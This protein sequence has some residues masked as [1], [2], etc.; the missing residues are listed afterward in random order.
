[1]KRLISVILSA[2][3]LISLLTA[4]PSVSAAVIGESSVA[5]SSGTTGDCT[6]S[7]DSSTGN[8]T[9]TGTGDGR[10][11]YYSDE[12]KLPWYS[13]RSKI[14]TLT[15]GKGVT[16]VTQNAFRKCTELTTVKFI[17][18][19]QSIA[20]GAFEYCTKLSVANLNLPLKTIGTYAFSNTALT[21]VSLPLSV[22]NV[23]SSAY[24]GCKNLKSVKVP[25]GCAASIDNAFSGCDA[26]TTVYLGSSVSDIKEAFNGC[27]ITEMTVSSSNP[28]LTMSGSFLL[29]KDKTKLHYYL[30]G[31]TD[32]YA[33]IPS[34]VTEIAD[35]AFSSHDYI[36]SVNLPS[37]LKK[38]G[39]YAFSSVQISSFSFPDSLESVGYQ[40]FY[41]T[42]WLERQP[43]GMV[44][45]GKVAYLY[46]G[47][48]PQSVSFKSDTLGIAGGAFEDSTTLKSITFPSTLTN[49]G[50]NAFSH[51]TN[52]SSM[53][54]PRSLKSIGERAFS[55]CSSLTSLVMRSNVT[56]LG[57][58]C[59][60]NCTSLKS[61]EL[62][63]NLTK[64]PADC[65]W[66]CIALEG[67]IVIPKK[68]EYIGE[69]AFMDT[70]K[71]NSF[72]VLNPDMQY[73]QVFQNSFGYGNKT[74]TMY[75]FKDSTAQKYASDKSW[76]F[77]CITEVKGDANFDGVVTIRD[78]TAIQR[79]VSEY[80]KLSPQAITN[81][82]M[83]HNS[84]A[85]IDDA[86]VIQ[87]YLAEY[88][89]QLT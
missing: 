10:M 29:S 47:D 3:I 80:Q 62:S 51:C 11:A 64:I 22:T 26:L 8:M 65:F 1:M 28:Y 46:K 34:T 78:V 54:L 9:I 2:M 82:D 24:Y 4:A 77:T 55:T 76:L 52:L 59:F 42:P 49:I 15:L 70:N 43:N 41:N 30:G 12:T 36:T 72:T 23:S 18:N 75:G 63:A 68:V 44:Y 20:Y 19:I 73:E 81:I 74:R 85:D 5:A 17:G 6:W 16:V 56:E 86:T 53:R 25:D 79:A 14:K 83:T 87:R 35:S 33:N 61:L 31:D 88:S 38:I 39:D 60:M 66:S 57:D 58:A 50:K 40:A 37:N 84:K 48:V 13:L 71:V 89:A 32:F 67:D 21:S 45:A 69:Y 7:F 27:P